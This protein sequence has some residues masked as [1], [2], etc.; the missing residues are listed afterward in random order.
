MK[1]SQSTNGV[2][3]P[4]SL[5]LNG[6]ATNRKQKEGSDNNGTDVDSDDSE[7]ISNK[8]KSKIASS[9]SEKITPVVHNQQIHSFSG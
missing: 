4:A 7:E 9:G 8:Q 5:K 6:T 2:S 3:A 1:K